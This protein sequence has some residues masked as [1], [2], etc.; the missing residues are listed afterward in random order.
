[1][2]S[3]WINQHLQKD[4]AW[5]KAYVTSFFNFVICIIRGQESHIYTHNLSLT[6]LFK[7]SYFLTLANI[8]CIGIKSN[9]S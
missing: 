9:T 1:M 6:Q 4:D 7:K 3:H 8:D 2:V 5:R